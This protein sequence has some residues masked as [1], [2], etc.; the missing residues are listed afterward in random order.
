MN[1][2]DVIRE[3]KPIYKDHV[4]YPHPRVPGLTEANVR[5]WSAWAGSQATLYDQIALYLAYGSHSSELTFT[6]CDGAIND[7]FGVIASKGEHS[8]DF[9]WAAYLAFDEG[10]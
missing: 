1:F 9:F 2:S 4:G 6:F 8:P 3:L 10:E 5:C 7:L